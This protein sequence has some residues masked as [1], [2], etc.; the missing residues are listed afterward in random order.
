MKETELKPNFLKNWKIEMFWD[1]CIVLYGEIYNDAKGRFADGTHIRTSR[2]EYIDFV[3][4]VA[5]TKNSTYNIKMG[6]RQ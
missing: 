5:K 6:G 3:D 1:G 4:G 2:V